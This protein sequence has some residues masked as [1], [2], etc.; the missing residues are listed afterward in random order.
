M[1]KIILINTDE[2]Y[3]KGKNRRY[4]FDKLISHINSVLKKH[5]KQEVNLK[6]EYSRVVLTCEEGL[7]DEVIR[8]LSDIPGINSLLVGTKTE[9]C[10]KEIKQQV[11]KEIKQI[12][13]H[14]IT[15]KIN[16]Q[17]SNKSFPVTSMDCSREIGAYVL[18]HFPQMKVKLGN[19]ELEIKVKIHQHNSYVISKN[20][21]GI[22]GLPAGTNGHIVSL[23]S[24]GFDSPVASYLMSK[25][26]CKLTFVFFYAHPFV[27]ED[28][29]EKI[30]ALANHLSRYQIKTKLNIV[31]FGNIQKEISKT[32]R[33]AY[34]TNFFRLAMI[35]CAN[36]LAK[37]I[38]ADGL[39]TGDSLG[40]V[41]SQTID[42]I[43]LLDKTSELPVF[44]PLIG[45]NK[46]EII[47]ISKKIGTFDISKLQHDDACSMFAP[48]HPIINPD[49][50]YWDSY[51]NSDHQALLD[52]ALKNVQIIYY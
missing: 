17:R 13:N 40:Q 32:C 18:E 6:K 19:P 47:D 42:S 44:R 48:K 14:N 4:F 2:L 35:K 3:L 38:G 22:G 37:K 24:G 41:S 30:N 36:Q 16:T 45:L 5:S 43:I 11:I 31:P 27:G 21:R 12:E 15:F 23:L 51:W 8:F 7:S 10:I 49:R 20:I 46:Q 28:V 9:N 39:L 1:N 29:K 25:R 50:E 33:P 26:G 52:E 34:R